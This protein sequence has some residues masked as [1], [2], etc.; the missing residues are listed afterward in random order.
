MT[1]QSKCEGCGA[2][3]ENCLAWR[4]SIDNWTAKCCDE[5]IHSHKKW[6]GAREIE[7][8]IEDD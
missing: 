3:F 8:G 7:G 4:K 2:S 1:D 6:D 5:C